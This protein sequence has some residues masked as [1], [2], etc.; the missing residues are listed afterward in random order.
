MCITSNVYEVFC[1]FVCVCVCF[2]GDVCM[3]VCVEVCV[4]VWRC[5]CV[6]VGG[7]GV[8]GDCIVTDSELYHNCQCQLV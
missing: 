2:L 6:C 5:V 8:G 4:C 7:G 3:C 1:L